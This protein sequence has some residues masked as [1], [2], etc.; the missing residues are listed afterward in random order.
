MSE[1]A[2]EKHYS[3]AELSKLL[4]LKPATIRT[5][6]R[7]GKIKAV[8]FGG[9]KGDWRIPESEAVR[10]VNDAYGSAPR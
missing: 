3:V 2:I 5:W 4:G 9:D 7:E 10:L 8:K 6:I 1:S